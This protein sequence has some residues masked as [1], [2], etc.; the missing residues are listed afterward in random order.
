[1]H[2]TPQ[3]GS[4][5]KANLDSLSNAVLQKLHKGDVVW[6]LFIAI[7]WDDDHVCGNNQAH[8]L[9][10]EDNG[11]VTHLPRQKAVNSSSNAVMCWAASNTY[12]LH[13]E[14]R[15]DQAWPA[16]AALCLRSL[17]RLLPP[18]CVLIQLHLG[19]ERTQNSIMQVP[20][21]HTAENS[22]QAAALSAT[23][24]QVQDTFRV[25]IR[26]QGSFRQLLTRMRPV[27]FVA[28]WGSSSRMSRMGTPSLYFCSTV[29][30][31]STR[32]G[33][34]AV[35]R[36]NTADHSRMDCS[37]ALQACQI[38]SA[39]IRSQQPL[40]ATCLRADCKSSS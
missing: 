8:M 38:F 15:S 28:R 34:E 27:S 12:A 1:M 35:A 11:I 21:T 9:H 3:K 6:T 5:H 39:M 17:H 24:V 10:A 19:V 32:P 40:R 16:D 14:C 26:K 2:K 4:R 33:S 23:G 37:P 25:A 7:P 29:C 22:L 30:V 31:E 18:H 20:M 36:Q 13:L